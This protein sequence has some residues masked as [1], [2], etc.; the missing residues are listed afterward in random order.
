MRPATSM[1]HAAARFSTTMAALS[2]SARWVV[3][4]L[5]L[6]AVG[7]AELRRDIEYG[8]AAGERLLL[9]V[10]VPEGAGPYPIAI[11]VHGGG[12]SRGDKR[13]SDQP[14]SGADI[15]PWFEPLTRAKFTWFSINYR[16]A[17]KHR[18]PACLEDV[19]TAIR[20]VKAHGADYKGDPRRIA[21][22]GHSA[23]GHLACLASTR[24]DAGTRVQAI[25]GFAPVTDFAF[26]LARRGGLGAGLQALLNRPDEITPE[27][28]AL[29][30][31]MSPI[32]HVHAGMPPTLLLN[33]EAD[34]TV[35]LQQTINY[36]ERLR[37]VG[38]PT[39][40]ITI[41]D[42]P[43][44]L[45]AWDRLDPIYP[46]K[47]IAWLDRTL[48]ASVVQ[49][50]LIVAADGSGDFNTVQQALASLPRDNRE[51]RIIAIRDGV[52]REKIRI[53]VPRITLRGTSRHGTR[54]EF[55]QGN[56]EFKAKGD[57]IGRAVV[58]VEAEDCVL[59]NLTIENTHGVMGKHAFTIYGRACDRTVI[60]D[61]DVFSQGNDT[62]S[63]WNSSRGRYYHARLNVR[64]SVDFV[65]PRGWCYLADSLLYEVQPHDD[66][67]IWH[68]GSKNRDQ[69]FVLR[70]CRFDGLQDWRLIR[71]HVDAQ[72]YL[73]DCTFSKTMRD[74]VPARSL[75]PGN[76]RTPTAEDIARNRELDP[77]N[78]WGNRVYFWN[79]H[80]DV[81]DYAWH[82]DNLAAAPGA[83]RSEQITA[84]WTFAGGWN[85]ERRDGPAI[86]RVDPRGGDTA[87]VFSE[88][89]TVKGRPQL[90][91]ADGST[92][93]FVSG[94]GSETLIFSGTGHFKEIAWSGGV[95][96]ASEAAAALR[97]AAVHLR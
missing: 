50:D 57:E 28:R 24:G 53:D 4:C 30:R 1:V 51:R 56:D 64:G 82:A 52:Y 26:P 43:H 58:N 13:G 79:C 35:E 38:V 75:F 63:L 67:S 23:G 87:V 92:G 85:P 89:V 72:F 91:F 6:T 39:E 33:G 68:D 36:H 25:V 27:V 97:F 47:V 14:G 45:L 83:P 62:I 48:S 31:E 90:V 20:W 41:K 44:S 69:K 88:S 49:P 84:E 40:L 11:L 16:L 3:T 8:T 10:N 95:I 59:E 78:V 15:T 76:G 29:L 22:F 70:N 46:A 80:G 94:S 73:L 21:V 18:W 2:Q 81:T 42:A 74:S 86:V 65:C 7:R 54:I 32:T 34:Q 66:A 5:V 37:A 77:M 60:V 17:P 55:A 61:C 71:W 96:V 93:A 19:Q 12:W 9:D